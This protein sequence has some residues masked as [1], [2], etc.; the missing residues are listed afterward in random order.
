ML[1]FC[2]LLE[3]SADLVNQNSTPKMLALGIYTVS[4]VL[5][6][7]AIWLMRRTLLL[8]RRVEQKYRINAGILD[9]WKRGLTLVKSYEDQEVLLGL[10]ILRALNEA[11]NKFWDR[12]TFE[13][14]MEHRNER[15]AAK[16]KF[17]H[18]K[19]LTSAAESSS[20]TTDTK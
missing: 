15:I 11:Q 17:I 7:T 10:D 3:E 5:F 16:A 19:L 12:P 1:A 2:I 6:I 14:L 4:I 9:D 18:E 13:A 20:P 8:R